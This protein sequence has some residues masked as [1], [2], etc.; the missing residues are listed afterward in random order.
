MLIPSLVFNSDP[1]DAMRPGL[2]KQ[3]KKNGHVTIY[4][5]FLACY[6]IPT[7]IVGFSSGECCCDQLQLKA[8]LL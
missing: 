7:A 4:W 8:L 6:L 1:S 2:K 5:A 3:Q